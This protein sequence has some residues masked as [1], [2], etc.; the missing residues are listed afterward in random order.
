MYYD[1]TNFIMILTNP[2]IPRKSKI[3]KVPNFGDV[4]DLV[5]GI[6]FEFG[7]RILKNN[8]V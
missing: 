6:F 2:K 8:I 7:S 5:I 4:L 1:S 3:L